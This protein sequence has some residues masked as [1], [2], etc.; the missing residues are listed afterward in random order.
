MRKSTL[1][2][3]YLLSSIALVFFLHRRAE[4]LQCEPEPT[5]MAIQHGDQIDCRIDPA[6][7]SD[8][9]QFSGNT[10]DKVFIEVVAKPNQDSDFDPKL[11]LYAPDGTLLHPVPNQADIRQVDAQLLQ[12]GT[13][14]M[15]V[16]E[17]GGFAGN[18]LLPGDYAFT[19]TC[20]GGSCLPL[21]PFEDIDGDGEVNATDLC[22]STPPGAEVDQNGCSQEEF[23]TAID[24]TTALGGQ[25]CKK[26]DWQNDEPLMKAKEADCVVDR[27]GSGLADDLCVSR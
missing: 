13:Y 7:D 6:D 1:L 12:T 23:C 3:S 2:I 19:V 8:E 20:L 14:T 4:A 25:R 5:H 16:Y 26:A 27:G 11:R 24:A 9:F 18:Q 22:P 10:G 21:L 15:R 17:I